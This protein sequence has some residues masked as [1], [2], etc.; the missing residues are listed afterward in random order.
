MSLWSPVAKQSLDDDGL[1]RF[2]RLPEWVLDELT[3]DR[4]H[5]V[6]SMAA[7]I[8][9]RFL[10]G[11]TVSVVLDADDRCGPVDLL[12]DGRLVARQPLDS[13]VHEY[14]FD[15]LDSAR[16]VEL[17]LP[18]FGA[19]R[20]GRLLVDQAEPEVVPSP[21]RSWIA[22]GSSLTQC[23]GAAGPSET[24]PARVAQSFGLDLE[25]LG[26]AGECHADIAIAEYI[27]DRNPRIV[28]LCLGTNVHEQS[29]MSLRTWESTV[30]AFLRLVAD[31]PGGQTIV[32]E[33]IP[34]PMLD[35]VPNQLGATL[36][37]Y[38]TVLRSVTD[39]LTGQLTGLRSVSTARILDAQE[40]TDLF[41]DGIHPT[42]QGYQVLGERLT[43]LL[44]PILTQFDSRSA[45]TS[46]GVP[47]STR[48]PLENT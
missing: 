9:A 39:R 47:S 33:A 29:T 21:G 40:N 23:A 30:S 22:Y 11:K 28:T 17:W 12:A 43:S 24:W 34:A 25:C 16:T 6:A 10:A 38:R 4:M 14:R 20:A 32:I 1:T 2:T 13:G 36:D 8:R 19:V 44:R 18:Q 37:D 7:G 3:T 15:L 46:T 26:L 31:R 35:A 27:R 5:D 48:L 41:H 45:G 42:A